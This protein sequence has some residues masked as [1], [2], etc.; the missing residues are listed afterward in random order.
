MGASTTIDLDLLALPLLF[1]RM[2]RL[3]RSQDDPLHD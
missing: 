1:V 3:V 2:R